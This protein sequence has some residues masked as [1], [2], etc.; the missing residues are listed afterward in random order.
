LKSSLV[1]ILGDYIATFF[2]A[3]TQVAAE[4]HKKLNTHE[5]SYCCAAPTHAHNAVKH[6]KHAE[7]LAKKAT[8]QFARASSMCTDNSVKLTIQSAEQKAIDA[9]ASGHAAHNHLLHNNHPS[10]IALS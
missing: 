9:F 8:M 10:D 1:N 7:A 6:L 5:H 4:L 2:H 3:T